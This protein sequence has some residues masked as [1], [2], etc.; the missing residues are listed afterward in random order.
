M[1]FG[2]I[3]PPRPPVP[4]LPAS[5]TRLILSFLLA[6]TASSPSVSTFPLS[7][8]HTLSH[9]VPLPISPTLSHP[10]PLPI[11]P[12]LSHPPYREGDA[13][14][15]R[16]PT[17]DPRGSLGPSDPALG[18][19]APSRMADAPPL[20]HRRLPRRGGGVSDPVQMHPS[21]WTGRRVRR[22]RQGI[23]VQIGTQES[24]KSA[25]THVRREEVT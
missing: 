20:G 25:R 10:V 3:R 5:Q 9:P 4:R 15:L 8:S 2:S 1:F 23:D 24:S 16:G 11:S 21:R 19:S 18:V 7:P 13:L 6:W 17:E 12:T 22:H 14:V